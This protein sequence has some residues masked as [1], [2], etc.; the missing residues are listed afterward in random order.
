MFINQPRFRI[1][2]T[3]VTF[4]GVVFLYC[5]ELPAKFN[6]VSGCRARL[7][8]LERIAAQVTRQEADLDAKE[9]ALGAA[10]AQLNNIKQ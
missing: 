8:Q 3:I 6:Y 1:A 10:E 2:M 7:A 9:K 5:Y 4:A